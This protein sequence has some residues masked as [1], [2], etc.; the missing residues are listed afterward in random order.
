MNE[1]PLDELLPQ[2]HQDMLNAYHEYMAQATDIRNQITESDMKTL[3]LPLK[4]EWYE[5]IESGVKTEEYRGITA[6]WIVRFF[7]DENGKKITMLTANFLASNLEILKWWIESGKLVFKPFDFV[8]F[9]YGYTKRTM[10]FELKDIS[11]GKG[12]PELGA[13]KEDVFIINLK[14]W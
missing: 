3:H 1:K 14:K 2:G 7:I 12:K 8:K 10:T 4:K 6:Y 5:M 11:I 13:P 9:S